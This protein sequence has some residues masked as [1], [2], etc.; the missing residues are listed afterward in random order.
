VARFEK[1]SVSIVPSVVVFVMTIVEL[2]SISCPGGPGKSDVIISSNTRGSAIIVATTSGMTLGLT[3]P[4][5]TSV[6]VGAAVDSIEYVIV[7]VIVTTCSDMP[8][9]GVLE[10][11]GF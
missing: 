2:D 5:A 4:R 7:E 11:E 10:E 1:A 6:E 3:N 8:A 9:K